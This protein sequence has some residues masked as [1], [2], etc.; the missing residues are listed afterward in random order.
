[1][2]EDHWM[3]RDLEA[4]P[5]PLEV[6]DDGLHW[7]RGDRI[8]EVERFVEAFDRGF[9]R[10]APGYREQLYLTLLSD[11]S[12]GARHCA[13]TMDERVVSVGS[14][15]HDGRFALLMNLATLPAYRRRGCSRRNYDARM[16]VAAAAG[17]RYVMFQTHAALVDRY[18]SDHPLCFTAE[19]YTRP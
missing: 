19:I 10:L 1:M 3:C 6:P 16:A 5:P 18:A 14:L 7:V 12:E 11:R 9:E 17:C 13:L 8:D 4:S 2:D 15:Y